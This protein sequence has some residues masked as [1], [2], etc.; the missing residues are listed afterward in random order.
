MARF[1]NTTTLAWRDDD[2]TGLAREGELRNPDLSAVANVPAKY[3][4]IVGGAVVE[5]TAEQKAAIDA[6]DLQAAKLAKIAAID[7]RTG[8]LIASGSV[9]VNG[10]DISTSLAAQTSLNG[11]KSA[12]DFGLLTFPQQVSATNGGAYT[13]NSL[14]DFKRV[15]GL[16]MTFVLTTKADGRALRQQVLDATTIAE[17]EAVEDNR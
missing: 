8:D 9:N 3:W 15:G 1:L 13:I 17:V 11:M 6:A 14:N 10:V 12:S 16:V 2:G 5:M 7:A 4:R